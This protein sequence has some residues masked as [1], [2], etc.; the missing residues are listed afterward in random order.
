MEVP[1]FRDMDGT[2]STATTID[3]DRAGRAGVSL[4]WF[5][6]GRNSVVLPLGAMSTSGTSSPGYDARVAVPS[7][8]VG[9]KKTSAKG[10]LPGI[11]VDTLTREAFIDENRWVFALASPPWEGT[12][13]VQGTTIA[14]D[15]RTTDFE[16]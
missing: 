8:L 15:G 11:V 1:S 13:A 5:E 4:D 3:R 6:Y 7:K 12:S 14:V 10:T 16:A 9:P 2:T